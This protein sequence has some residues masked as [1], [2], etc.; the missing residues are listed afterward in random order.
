MLIIDVKSD[1]FCVL[2]KW[3]YTLLLINIKESSA[4]QFTISAHKLPYEFLIILSNFRGRLYCLSLEAVAV[5]IN[6]EILKREW[7]SVATIFSK[8][9]RSKCFKKHNRLR[10]FTNKLV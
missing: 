8:C 1:A 5:D 9:C 3:I 7:N 10:L 6:V 4:Q 2:A